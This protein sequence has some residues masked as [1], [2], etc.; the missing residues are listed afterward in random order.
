[1]VRKLVRYFLFQFAYFKEF[2]CVSKSNNKQLSLVIVF[3]LHKKK[4]LQRGIEEENALFEWLNELL[5]YNSFYTSVS[6]H[7]TLKM[8]INLTINIKKKKNGSRS[9]YRKEMFVVTL[10]AM[11][12]A[13]TWAM[14]AEKC[15]FMKNCTCILMKYFFRYKINNF[16]FTK[17]VF[18][19]LNFF[20]YM[21]KLLLKHYSLFWL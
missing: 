8:S 6:A 17:I 2:R 13:M 19:R 9:M 12:M 5:T 1:M 20:L 18:R 11:L 3:V 4:T 14:I 21:S 10:I 7:T 16:Y 15:Y